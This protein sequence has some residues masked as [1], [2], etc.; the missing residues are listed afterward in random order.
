MYLWKA[1]HACRARVVLYI[2]VALSIGVLCG[3]DIITWANYNT[4]W[5]AVPGLHRLVQ[6]NDFRMDI[7]FHALHWTVAGW[8]LTSAFIS[9]VDFD[10]EVGGFGMTLVLLT[11]LI[12]GSTGVG[13][14]YGADTM[15]FVLTRPCAR[16]N[17]ILTDWLVGL[18]AM[19]I[20]LSGLVLPLLPFLAAVHAK[21]SGNVLAA[22]PA[23][24]V[25]GAAIYGLSH[26]TTLVTGSASKGMILSVATFLTY[27]FLPTALHEW[28]HSDALLRAAEWTLAPFKYGAWPL[29]AFEWGA[30]TFWL[31]L[32]AGFLGA[33]L[34]WIKFREV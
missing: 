17:F 12:L 33:S 19:V 32:A 15:S 10:W 14:E 30:T 29:S 9:G 22:L 34:A 25:M 3:L 24:W 13:R 28:W 4:I 8:S 20:I 1:W 6:S 11:G 7:T 31:A 18:T 26:F 27:F 5:M 16:R 2:G 23:L 21:G